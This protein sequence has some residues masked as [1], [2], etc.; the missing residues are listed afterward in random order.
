ML[1]SES[2][3]SGRKA[4]FYITENSFIDNY[5]KEAG[6]LGTALYHVL[7]RYMNYETRSTW[8][9]TAKMADI[10]SVSQ[11]TVQR[12]LKALEDLKLIRILRSETRT[13]Y[14]V[15]PVPPRAKAAPTIPLFDAITEEDIMRIGDINDAWATSVSRSATPVTPKAIRVSPEATSV[16]HTSDT[17]DAPYKEEQNLLNKTQEQDFLNKASEQSNSEIRQTAERIIDI[18]GL[19]DSFIGAAEAAVGIRVKHTKLSMDG[20]VQRI[21]T[22]ANAA[23]RI[24][25]S[26]QKFL[27]DFLAQTCAQG[28]L[29]SLNLPVTNSLTST[30]TA[31][32]KAEAK[33]TRLSLEEAAGRITN[34]AIE[35]RGRGTPIDRFYFENVKWRS[36]AR[37]SKAEQ[38]KLDN[39]EV[40]ARAK[41]RLKEKLGIL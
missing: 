18:L 34:A 35:D 3:R 33:D 39:L 2:V 25:V 13:V 26:H 7:E 21:T 40:N 1:T 38:R 22:D 24:G 30:V 15:M 32:V 14:V 12:H 27:E 36:N 20:I 16:S 23:M 8:V 19:S 17:S 5:A 6:P 10:L 9:G 37:A 11:R 41:Q 4:N 31:A 28:I 29:D